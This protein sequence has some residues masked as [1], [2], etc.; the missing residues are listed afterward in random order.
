[1]SPGRLSGSQ[2]VVGPHPHPGSLASDLAQTVPASARISAVTSA[3]RTNTPHATPRVD[4][5]KKKRTGLVIV[6]GGLAGALLAIGGWMA[7]RQPSH[8]PEEPAPAQV[9]NAATPAPAPAVA[10]PEGTKTEPAAANPAGEAKAGEPKPGETAAAEPKPAEPKTGE[11]KPGEAKPAE[12]AAA[13]EAKPAEAKPEAKPADTKIAVAESAA[14]A[15]AGKRP[16]PP[17]HKKGA[18]ASK[19]DDAAS[20]AGDDSANVVRIISLPTGADVLI[21][22]QAVGKTPFLSKDIDPASPHALT[23]RKDGFDNHEHM[24]SP[25]DWVKGKGAG[26][27]LRV[28]VKL[29]KAAGGGEAKA[30]GPDKDDKTDKPAEKATEPAKTEAPPPAETP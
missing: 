21:D 10:A 8:E 22:G 17:L 2:P 27:S 9:N 13:A 25:G 18:A 20:D 4:P 15:K 29:H 16:R 11:A 3:V 7:F 30:G 23:V 6:V 1:M 5:P 12:P 24:V 26:Q 14:A 19:A 28:T